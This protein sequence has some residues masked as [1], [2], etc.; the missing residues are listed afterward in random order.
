[1]TLT[2]RRAR[3]APAVLFAT[4]LVQPSGLPA[5]D[6]ALRQYVDETTAASITVAT[7]PLIFARERSDLAVNARDYVVLTATEVNITGS[8]SH[9][10]S[11][12]IWSTI[13]RRDREPVVA[14]GDELVLVA[15]GRPI[16][17]RSDGKT[18]RDHG[19][20]QPPTRAPS[21]TAIPVLYAADRESISYVAHATELHIEL[22][23]GGSNE[24]FALWKD[25]R[26]ALRA[27]S[28]SVGGG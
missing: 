24:V 3:A 9:F 1:M 27:F 23:H 17:L 19:L 11:A 18:L 5:A 13:D 12:Y 15:D 20:G 7:Q 8:R 14:P 10:W 6:D 2:R 4:L 25:G 16:T 28:A 22:I 21:R 26:A